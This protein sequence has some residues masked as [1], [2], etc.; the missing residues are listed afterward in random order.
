LHSIQ[1]AEVIPVQV[2]QDSSHYWQVLLE[3]YSKD[4]AGQS[5]RQ[6]YPYKKLPSLHD[7]MIIKK[8]NDIKLGIKIIN[9]EKKTIKNG[10][11]IKKKYISLIL[12]IIVYLN[13]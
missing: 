4:P 9:R 7:L 13:F 10:F 2:S 8:L 3:D 6:L 12:K 11:K 5:S 1:S